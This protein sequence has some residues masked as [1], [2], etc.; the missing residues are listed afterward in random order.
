MSK[1][2]RAQHNA[3]RRHGD[4]NVQTRYSKKRQC[5]EVVTRNQEAGGCCDGGCTKD[6]GTCREAKTV[7]TSCPLVFIPEIKI[8]IG[9]LHL[10]QDEHME[11]FN[12]NSGSM[13]TVLHGAG[14]SEVETKFEE[15]DDYGE[16][17]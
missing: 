4:R 7:E 6:A 15:E 14:D 5:E 16:E 8:K 17:N 2:N 11:T 12:F 13:A 10:H 3:P 9:E 1:K